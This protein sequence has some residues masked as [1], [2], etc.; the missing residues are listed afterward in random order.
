MGV[1]TLDDETRPMFKTPDMLV[2]A[3]SKA[4]L[5]AKSNK[6]STVRAFVPRKNAA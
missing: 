6:G 1:S 5:A 4:V 2:Q 3:A